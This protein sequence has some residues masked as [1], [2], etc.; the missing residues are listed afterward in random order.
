MRIQALIN[1]IILATVTAFAAF[2]GYLFGIVHANRDASK[3]WV[4]QFVPIE[5]A[6]AKHIRNNNSAAA[7][8][9]LETHALYYAETLEFPEKGV[10]PDKHEMRFFLS[11]NGGRTDGTMDQR[12]TKANDRRLAYL[13]AHPEA[14]HVLKR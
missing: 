2:I 10:L 9:L 5:L 14:I 7:L 6:A 11:P 8:K 1:H 3:E 4:A 13:D 12:V